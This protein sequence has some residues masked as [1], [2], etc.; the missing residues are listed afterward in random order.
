[1]RSYGHPT[2]RAPRAGRHLVG[3]AAGRLAGRA[4]G[5]GAGAQPCG[6]RSRRRAGR[7]HGTWQR[8][9][10]RRQGRGRERETGSPGLAGGEAR[11]RSCASWA[12]QTRSSGCRLEDQ[13]TS[14]PTRPSPITFTGKKAWV[15]KKEGRGTG[16][17]R[18]R[19]RRRGHGGRRAPCTSLPAMRG[20]S[21]RGVGTRRP[22][23]NPRGRGATKRPAARASAPYCSP[24]PRN[25]CRPRPRPRNSEISAEAVKR[26]TTAA[27]RIE[28][29]C[30]RAQSR[31]V[32]SPRQ[33]TGGAARSTWTRGR[34]PPA[35][36]RP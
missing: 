19:G 10:S 28:P 20:S 36:A 33:G 3:R 7:R 25:T 15:R 27:G 17:A 11:T 23:Q 9:M 32:G 6:W 34:P 21:Q 5:A 24:S 16:G 22:S 4:P 13:P 18:H 30:H 2:I 35:A 31:I 1:M 8:P 29:T 26:G 12:A 14:R